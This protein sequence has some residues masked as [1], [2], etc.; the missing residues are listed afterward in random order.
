MEAPNFIFKLFE[1]EIIRIQTELLENVATKYDMD[2][3]ALI[4]E[5]IGGVT[6]VPSS[7]INI[8]V[9]KQLNPRTPPNEDNRCRARIW[10]RGRGGQCMRS[11]IDSNGDE[12]KYCYQH[13]TRRK[14]GTIDEPPDKSQFPKTPTS[15]YK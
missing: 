1:K 2:K 10:N 5:F 8:V 12:C 6:L 4:Q 7:K 13:A 3:D 14:L 9:H 11:R 15:L